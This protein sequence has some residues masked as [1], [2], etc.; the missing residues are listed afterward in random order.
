MLCLVAKIEV[1]YGFYQWLNQNEECQENKH[2]LATKENG[3]H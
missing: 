1:Y 3:L 2:M